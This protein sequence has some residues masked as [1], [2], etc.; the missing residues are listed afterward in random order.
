MGSPVKV[1]DTPQFMNKIQPDSRLAPLNC[2]RRLWLDQHSRFP[3]Y[4]NGHG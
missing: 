1:L 3:T 2:D 4:P